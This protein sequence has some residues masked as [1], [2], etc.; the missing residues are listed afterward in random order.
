M[1]RREKS[2][3]SANAGLGAT[4]WPRREDERP[5]MGRK[6][7]SNTAALAPKQGRLFRF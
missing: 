7:K 6:Q 4:V 5:I 2:T 3:F 1:I